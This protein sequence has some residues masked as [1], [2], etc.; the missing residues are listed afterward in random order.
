VRAQAILG[1]VCAGF[2][3]SLAGSPASAQLLDRAAWVQAPPERHAEVLVAVVSHLL[4]EG[5]EI[6]QGRCPLGPLSPDCDATPTPSGGQALLAEAGQGTIVLAADPNRHLGGAQFDDL[7]EREPDSPGDGES[8]HFLTGAF[9][10]DQTGDET[11]MKKDGAPPG[12]A[13]CG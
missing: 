8:V 1:L 4:T 2:V 13:G 5:A 10:Q 3:V 9:V 7:D 12:K 11:R 6:L